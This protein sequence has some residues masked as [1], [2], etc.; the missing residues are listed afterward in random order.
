MKWAIIGGV[1]ISNGLQTKRGLRAHDDHPS[2][3]R[4]GVKHRVTN[5]RRL[6]GDCIPFVEIGPHNSPTVNP[7]LVNWDAREAYCP[8]GLY[9]SFT[10]LQC[11][12][13]NTNSRRVFGRL[14]GKTPSKLV[15]ISCRYTMYILSVPGK[16]CRKNTINIIGVSVDSAIRTGSGWQTKSS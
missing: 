12:K 14:S 1:C 16:M 13:I 11:L 3:E 2:W 7:T 15:Q 6:T 9:S 5:E 4:K 10:V 8:A